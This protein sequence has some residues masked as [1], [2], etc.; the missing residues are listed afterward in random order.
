MY[1]ENTLGQDFFNIF[2]SAKHG[3]FWHGF[4]K[5]CHCLFWETGVGVSTVYPML[6]DISLGCVC[7]R[8]FCI[9]FP[10]GF[11][12]FKYIV[13]CYLGCLHP[14]RFMF[15]NNA[16]MCGKYLRCLKEHKIL[17]CSLKFL[18]T[19][20]HFFGERLLHF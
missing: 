13:L 1:L 3:V 18:S 8:H 10:C 4:T 5:M 15:L 6:R 16:L 11:C 14:L 19:E 12:I 20:S 9:R 2:W 7:T 17:I